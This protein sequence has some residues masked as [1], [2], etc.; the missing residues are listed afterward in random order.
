MMRCSEIEFTLTSCRDE[1]Y[2]LENT[3][4]TISKN[5]TNTQYI[6][7]GQIVVKLMPIFKYLFMFDFH[8]ECSII[9]STY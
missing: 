5:G 1:R 3:Q 9:Y 8:F 6:L 7:Q 4:L 2:F